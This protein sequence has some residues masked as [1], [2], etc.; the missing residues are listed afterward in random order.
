MSGSPQAAAAPALPDV[1]ALSHPFPVVQHN[2]DR[3][4]WLNLYA[5][6]VP[7]HPDDAWLVQDREDFFGIDG[8]YGIDVASRLHRFD[9]HLP[10]TPGGRIQVSQSVGRQIG[11]L[12]GR[13]LFGPEDLPWAPGREPPP[14]IFDPWRPQSFAM[15]D[16][17]VRFADGDDGFRGY[18]LGRTYP[19][20]ASGRPVLLAGAVGDVTEGRGKLAGLEATFVLNGVF[21][22]LG[23]EGNVTCRVVDPDGRLAADGDPPP[24][25]GGAGVS[26]LST[27][28]VLRGEKS[29]PDVR[30]EY[31]PPPGPGLVSLVTPAQMRP[32]EFR[33]ATAGSGGLRSRMRVGQVAADLLADVTLD[34]L[35]PPGTPDRPNF[36]TTHNVYTFGDGG[37]E[38]S[39]GAVEADVDLGRS[40]GLRFRDLPDQPAMRYGGIG[41]VAVGRGQFAG[42]V[43]MLAVNSAIGVAPHALSMVNVLQIVDPDGRLRGGGGG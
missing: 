37:G 21:H 1:N 10:P 16:V 6:P 9:S 23:F 19:A 34:I 41:P 30:T 12:R 17:D 20:S 13:V 11:E 35:A 40:F 22:R 14:R 18:G 3:A 24:V 26:P 32:V 29:G 2:L 43:G 39:V 36:F 25:D 33:T 28:L 27:F 38:G 5:S 42:M 4:A 7:G 15:L 8:G 31:G